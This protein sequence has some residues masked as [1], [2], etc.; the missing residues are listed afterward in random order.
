MNYTLSVKAGNLILA[1]CQVNNY[2]NHLNTRL[3]WYS[4]GRFVSGCQMV[5]IQMVVWKPDW[6]KPVN[7]PTYPLELN[8]KQAQLSKEWIMWNNVIGCVSESVNVPQWGE[9]CKWKRSYRARLSAKSRD[10]TIWI[11]AT[12]AFQYSDVWYLDGT[13][14]PLIE[15]YY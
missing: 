1:L 2:S 14:R 5:R 6:K 7:S 10:F 12:H 4:N 15:P 13:V 9:L 11:P 8:N 3:L